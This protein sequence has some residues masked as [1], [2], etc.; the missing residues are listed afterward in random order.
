MNEPR[1]LISASL[2]EH[3]LGGLELRSDRRRESAAVW[4]GKVDASTDYVAER[5]YFHHELCDDHGAALSLELTEEAKFYLYQKL[6]NE[7]LRLIALLHT[8]PDKWVDLSAVD[9]SNQLCSRVGFWSI[10]VPQYGKPPWMPALMGVHV[11]RNQ[12]WHR[13][14]PGEV[15]RRFVI[16]AQ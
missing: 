1:L 3:T 14:D 4:A 8:H 9:Q 15:A 7:G 5:V 12:G 11:R 2:F 6:S 16:N 13:L 10:V